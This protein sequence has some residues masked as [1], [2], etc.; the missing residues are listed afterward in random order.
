M[1]D[2]QLIELVQSKPP[3]EL[4]F[5]E[6]DA[7][8]DGLRRSAALREALLDRLHMEQYL[9][10]ALGRIEVSVDHILRRAAQEQ[11]NRSNIGRLLG[12]GVALCVLLA[13]GLA[14]WWNQRNDNNRPV[15]QADG[16]VNPDDGEKPVAADVTDAADNAQ[17]DVPNGAKPTQ[18]NDVAT[19]NGGQPGAQNKS[20]PPTFRLVVEAE[21]FNRGNVEIREGAKG[22]SYVR[23]RLPG[24]AFMDYDIDVPA[25]GDYRLEIRYAAD[26]PLPVRL[27]INGK[28]V[29]AQAA[30]KD[31]GGWSE[32]DQQWHNE[33]VYSLAKG[34]NIIRLEMEAFAKGT[35]RQTH[36][37][38][39]DQLAIVAEARPATTAVAAPAG[40]PRVPDPWAELVQSTD[41]PP[42]FDAEC[43]NDLPFDQGFRAA[44]LQRYIEQVPGQSLKIREQASSSVLDGLGR[45]R[46]P[47]RDDLSLRLA[48]HDHHGLKLH[49]WNEQQGVTLWYYAY[50][51]TWVAYQTTRTNNDPKPA[52]FALAATD[53]QRYVRT[54]V[55]TFELRHADGRLTM[56]RGNVTLLSVPLASPPKEAYVEGRASV[57]GMALARSAGL[58]ALA[59]PRPTVLKAEKPALMAWKT[60][61]P[62]GTKLNKLD[63]GAVELAA[64][65]SAATA[66]ASLPLSE[67]GLYEAIFE[68]LDPQPGTG[69]FLGD[70]KGRP[71]HQVAFFRES[72]TGWPSF[73]FIPPGDTRIESNVDINQQLAPYA[74]KRQWL[75]LVLGCGTLKCWISPDGV[76]WSRVL[77]PVQSAGGLAAYS[78]LGVY[79]LKSDKPRSIQLNRIEVRELSGLT[80]LA[81]REVLERALSLSGDGDMEL[82][83]WLQTVIENQPAGVDQGAWRRA[84]AIR[85]LAVGP[86]TKLALGLLTGLL[87]EGLSLS[88]P[89]AD[90]LRLLEDAALLAPTWEGAEAQDLAN[91][92]ARRYERLGKTLAHE[93]E[94]RPYTAVATALLTAPIATEAQLPTIP[95]SLVLEELVNLMERDQWEE[96]VDVCRRLEYWTRTS[97]S[98]RRAQ[99]REGLMALCE[100]TQGSAFRNL[101]SKRGGNSTVL[102][103]E[104]R[105]PL[106]EVLSKEGYN[107]LAEF[108]AALDGES[109]ADACQIISN[110]DPQGA[111]GLLPDSRDARLLISLPG[112]VSLAMREHPNLRQTMNEQF[113]PRGR[114]R[115]QQA[116]ADGDLVAL[117]AATTQFSGTQA[118]AEAH[119]W[120]GDRALSSG[121]FTHAIGQYQLALAGHLPPALLRPRLRLSAALLG[122]NEG[123]PV[124]EPVTLG[125]ESFTAAEFET[126]V[127]DALGNRSTQDAPSLADMSAGRDA[128]VPSLGEY[129]A[130][131]WAELKGAIGED[132][133]QTPYR[134]LD[135]VGRQTAVTVAGD[136]MYVANRFQVSAYELDGGNRKW[137]TE[138]EGS[139]RTH[140][141][142]LTPM[143]PAVTGDRLFVRR[144][145]KLGPDLV[146]LTT[147]KGSQLWRTKF[148]QLVLCDPLIVQDQLFVLTATSLQD[149]LMQVSLCNVDPETGSV[150][151]QRPLFQL[152]DLW[153]RQIPSHAVV[154]DDKIVATIGGSVVCCD[155]LGQV[156]WLRRQTWI[157]QPLE[158][159]W[160]TRYRQAPLVLPKHVIV[161]APGVR[162]VEC[163][164]QSSGRRTWH[165]V[166]PDLRRMVGIDGDKLVLETV[167]GLQGHDVETGQLVWQREAADLLHAQ[168]CGSSGQVVYA[169]KQR[170]GPDEWRVT[171]VWV[172]AQTGIEAGRSP[173]ANLSDKS[174]A[175]GPLVAHQ[176]RLWMCFGRGGRDTSREIYELVRQGSARQGDLAENPL[177]HWNVPLDEV[178]RTSAATALPGWTLLSGEADKQTRLHADV[179]GQSAV[180]ATLASSRRPVKFVRPLNVP[181]GSRAKLVLKVGHD[182]DAK[183]GLDVRVGGDSLLSQT[184]E[185]SSSD[186]GWKQFEVDLSRYSGRSEWLSVGQRDVGGK[187]SYAYWRKVDVELTPG[188]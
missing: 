66:I 102:K 54:G 32:K 45:L 132:P 123:A 1:T 18:P 150:L 7:L 152:R 171:L 113:G 23:H 41:A 2:D 181:Q 49:F 83:G 141:W 104:W 42:A 107:I 87:D 64:E 101:P 68:I 19:D 8:R 134:D 14:I 27:L 147:K 11:P 37:P 5:E 51:P 136:I 30:S 144:L 114:L 146:C 96:A 69:V 94:L 166:L 180:L 151:S 57:R 4:S 31:T 109:F 35:G 118:A 13:G 158:V 44:E 149:P 92:L 60:T 34:R 137:I 63:S 98:S 67:T 16:N 135:W 25:A 115:V 130:R 90:R 124:A 33:G 103:S 59:A 65:Q 28:E 24:Q 48:L 163:L 91:Q 70:A 73:G 127:A 108:N 80:S 117:E 167:T 105:H 89:A 3:E 162:T 175:A 29:K 62:A 170:G 6:L 77:T 84:C 46:S 143:T 10:H 164:E 56:T 174:P 160:E 131:R 76:H 43:F 161:S 159:A 15:A 116:I 17:V 176:D 179:R 184:V 52:T 110:A 20:D 75:R 120:L 12:W 58:P 133:Q 9:G 187:A 21:N 173:L 40:P 47:W 93:G 88:L 157:P 142:P 168:A 36:I 186:G 145:T 153:S 71:Q 148:S 177:R 182:P 185:T 50:P 99:G 106:V 85:S 38:F 125:N 55:G 81:P 154:V 126:L 22:Y 74:L 61:L 78:Q 138:F 139:G 53:D 140:S 122:R 95:E 112:A 156:R 129:E 121:D 100:W 72:R 39:F 188:K 82:G 111:L 26:E 155:L 165:L 128:I 183:W 97:D 169:C 178:L 119:L 172:D 86:R 79:C